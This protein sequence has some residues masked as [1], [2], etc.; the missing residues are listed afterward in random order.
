MSEFYDKVKGLHD[1]V[2]E[3][4]KQKY[5]EK[6]YALVESQLGM[7]GEDFCSIEEFNADDEE[8]TN[9]LIEML[10]ADG[11]EASY[12]YNSSSIIVSF[13]TEQDEE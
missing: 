12:D 13:K 5:F 2:C 8:V 6:A 11:F 4:R 3:S 7:Y 9:K 10:E 1:K